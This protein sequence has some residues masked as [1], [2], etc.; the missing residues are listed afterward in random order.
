[1]TPGESEPTA[2]RVRRKAQAREALVDFSESVT[3]ASGAA[4][5][6]FKPAKGAQARAKAR[7]VNLAHFASHVLLLALVLSA[8][9]SGLAYL[10]LVPWLSG[11]ASERWLQASSSPVVFYAAM[12][13]ATLVI[14]VLLVAAIYVLSRLAVPRRERERFLS[15]LPRGLRLARPSVLVS[16]WLAIG[17]ALVAWW[18]GGT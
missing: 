11:T 10:T 13:L 18:L 8:L 2:T 5:S 12:A 15:A 1:M 17:A 4:E 9:G 7:R 3:A 14:A 6:A 16:A